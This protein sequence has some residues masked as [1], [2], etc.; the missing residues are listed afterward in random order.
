MPT[1][2]RSPRRRLDACFL[3]LLVG[4]ALAVVPAAPL[5]A[6]PVG[7]APPLA[8]EDRSPRLF[9][10]THA[11]L[12]LAPGRVVD[13]GTL[14]IRDGMIVAAGARVAVP[15][16]A[17]TRDLAGAT[18]YPGLIDLS[19][20][21]GIP[22]PAMPA[23]VS[24]GPGGPTGGPGAG[25]YGGLA[26]PGASSWNP[27]V[28]P[29]RRIERDLVADSLAPALRRTLRGQGI[30][31]ALVAPSRGIVKGQGAVLALGDGPI[32]SLVLRPQAS[33][34]LTFATPFSFQNRG[35][36]T[37]PMGALAL[38]RQ[39]FLDA[40]WHARARA[41]VER[42][43]RLPRPE[44][45]EGLVAL[46]AFRGAGRPLVIEA[47]D[48]RDALRADRLGRELGLS[49]IVRGSGHEYRDLEGI[50][51]AGRPIVV[52]LAFP[53]APLVDSPEQ[54]RNVSLE[55]LMHWDLAPEN[56]AR[57]ARAGVT[58]A[59]TSDRLEDKATFLAQV[60]KA[61]ERGLDHDAALAALTVTPA[62]LLGLADRLGTLEPGRHANFVIT[63]GDLFSR[64]T[65][66]R[67]TWIDG[68][69][70][71]VRPGPE[72]DLRGRWMA[73]FDP[74]PEGAV[75]GDSLVLVLGG[76][77]DSLGGTFRLGRD[78]RLKSAQLIDRR[79]F[80]SVPGDSL[81][82]TGMVRLSGSFEDEALAGE[83][84]WPDGRSFTWS[85]RR[86]DRHAAAADTTRPRPVVAVAEP[87]H[88][89]GDFGRARLPEQPAAVAFEGA[90]V[91]TSGPQGIL[92]DATVVVERGK[93]R[94]V[95]RGVSVPAGALRIDARGK[96]L[97]PGLIDAHSHSA[98]D[99]GINE[100]GQTITA[101]VRIG[102]YIE[103][104][105]IAIYRQLAG[106]L[107]AAHVLHGS[108]NAIG[109]QSQL[110]KLRWGL[111]GEAMKFEGW[112]ATI[113][114]ALGENPKQSN[115]PV[116][117]G[118][119]ST[120]FPQ[121]RMGVEQL[122]RDRFTAAREYLADR[123]RGRLASG[124]PFRR[125]LELEA[126]GEIL[127]GRRT[128][129][130]HAYRQDE[131]LMLIRLADE[132]GIKVGTFQHILE[133]YKV[134]EAMARHG[135]AGSSF[136]DWWAYKMEVIDAIPYNGAL[137]HGAGVLVSFNSDS[138]ELARRLNTEAGKAVK[139]G[140][141]PAEEALKFVTLHPARQLRVEDRV[142]SIEP[143][144][145]A[146]LA[147][148][149]GPPLSA[150]SRCEQTWIDGRRY[151]DRAEDLELRRTQAA[152]KARLVQRALSE[153]DKGGGA[154]PLAQRQPRH[155]W[156]D[157]HPH[158]DG[159]LRTAADDFGG[160]GESEHRDCDGGGR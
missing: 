92:E 3:R 65:K 67:E 56:A 4:S 40:D 98:T 53:R 128:I 111:D 113:K 123:R 15:R 21:I 86:I 19:L 47:R 88:P 10:F 85:A 95:G 12:V 44:M 97:T 55:E 93:I 80:L 71:P 158:D 99:G 156:A 17:L 105:D 52:P 118:Q 20:P 27:L 49:V 39:T 41:A 136:S 116:P 127:E 131:I 57:L 25:G 153:D 69:N 137:M 37:S 101:E 152:I 62:R 121:S 139:Y 146:D 14:V 90:T 157:A 122:I 110:I 149:S 59:L 1:P 43:A 77:P 76:L 70:Y 84:E 45:D 36:P 142:G 35:Y 61:V 23:Q 31:A 89:F 72:V 112:P 132:F 2:D 114:F 141:V 145:D 22:A 87:N 129:H 60:R 32:G 104:N 6:S 64:T 150:L 126:I 81:G 134:A 96:H 13:D 143:G 73:T 5:A 159:G 115:L 82:M 108:A 54:A 144:K 33:L 75:P 135:A 28:A 103:P 130:C 154:G 140:G 83:G 29:Q 51:A 91:W 38:I 8:L 151:F 18:V 63:D 24:D 119:A 50:R 160:A 106:G 147:L 58:I 48:E 79:A 155:D 11:R 133:G 16:G 100:G 42:D 9:A 138:D 30:T 148:W 66:L 7:T 74:Q 107:T 117:A 124:L 102:D 120:R 34:H 78:T 68:V 26:A 125:D 94:A 109:G 46:A